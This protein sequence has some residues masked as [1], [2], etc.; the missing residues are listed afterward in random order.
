[1]DGLAKKLA[2][3]LMAA[4]VPMGDNVNVVLN[5]V[6]NNVQ[7][8]QN[9]NVLNGVLNNVQNI[10][11][12]N[13]QNTI[14]II[15]WDS[16]NRIR[17]SPED[18]IAAF[19]ENG[20]LREFENFDSGQMTDPAVSSSHIAE[21]YVDLI[22]R[23]HQDPCARNIYLNPRRADQVMVY[24]SRGTWDVE[25]LH[26]ASEQLLDGVASSM[27]RIALYP[28]GN[29]TLSSSTRNAVAIAKMMY[30][31]DHAEY[32]A[33]VKAPLVAHLSNTAPPANTIVI[34]AKNEDTT[35]L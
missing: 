30:D 7:N 22:K 1:V 25:C 9:H 13:V 21:L 32:L 35:A 15:P 18:I 8:I 4:L 6:V 12:N 10:Q 27:N 2:T 20:K 26:T 34:A 33:K 14:V 16:E 31:S 29:V 5:N 28:T 11:N 24:R 23:I 19:K 17:I 3:M